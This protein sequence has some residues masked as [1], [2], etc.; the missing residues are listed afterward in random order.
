[1]TGL[2]TERQN[3]T[4]GR[5]DLFFASKR[6]DGTF[7]GERLIGNTPAFK[8]GV[9]SQSVKHYSSAR[10]MKTQDREVPTQTDYS[11]SF[12]TDDVAPK[13]LAALFLGDA[14][15]EAITALAAQNESFADV[16][17]GLTYQIGRS[18]ANPAG[19]QNVSNVV[20]QVNATPMVLDTDYKL[21]AALGRITIIDGGGIN[22]GDQID[23]T[24]DRA[25][26]SQERV[27]AGSTVVE[28]YLRFIAYNPEGDDIDYYL[29]AVKLSPDGDFM[30]K[31]DQDWQKMSFKLSISADTAGVP[32]YANGRAYT[33]AP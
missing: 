27:V 26:Y 14:S 16:A 28:G 4:I 19:L 29:P 21:D 25:A 8:L 9:T 5:G 30:I 20:V 24:Y 22:D 32:I 1:M 31:T 13:N 17:Q 2:N 11:G 12:D 7:E 33:P 15:V 10:G 6:A 18:T 23:V 3:Y